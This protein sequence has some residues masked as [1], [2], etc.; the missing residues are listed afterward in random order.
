[1]T[2][3]QLVGKLRSENKRDIVSA[4]QS[5]LSKDEL[6]DLVSSKLKKEELVELVDA[7]NQSSSD[8]GDDDRQETESDSQEREHS[9]DTGHTSGAPSMRVR[10]VRVDLSGLPMMGVFAGRGTSAAGTITGVDQRKRE[11]KIW[12]DAAFDGEK[13]IVVPPERV[14]LEG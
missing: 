9:D 5:R 14:T 13:E 4:L 6:V 7:A 10:R 8:E 1:M 12:L 11:I 3:E 2:K